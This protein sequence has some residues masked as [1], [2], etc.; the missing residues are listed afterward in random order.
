MAFTSPLHNEKATSFWQ[1]DQTTV[2]VAA[3]AGVVDGKSRGD[4]AARPRRGELTL[5]AYVGSALPHPRPVS[6]TVTLSTSSG[7][8]T[9]IQITRSS[10]RAI[11]ILGWTPM[12]RST[13]RPPRNTSNAGMLCM[14]KR[15]AVTGFSSTLSFATR[16]RPASS[17]ANSSI[18]GAMIRQGWHHG[19]HI[20][21]STGKGDRS[22]SVENVASVTWMGWLRAGSGV[23]H[24]PH[25]GRSPCSSFSWGTRLVAP[26]AL[27]RINCG[28]D[29]S[30]FGLAPGAATI[31]LYGQ[32]SRSRLAS[33]WLLRTPQARCS[34]EYL[35]CL[36]PSCSPP[37][38]P[39][40]HVHSSQ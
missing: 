13:S 34:P 14:R 6:S 25:T 21:R 12:M 29:I 36:C 37:L 35:R 32:F 27:H 39:G 5:A 33:H 10:R 38:L 24:W 40:S 16:K 30:V 20:S 26:Q 15:P 3:F 4:E 17:T 8:A 11:S 2:K 23:L 7:R 9:A 28:G 31:S 18:V 22:T 19:A 1:E